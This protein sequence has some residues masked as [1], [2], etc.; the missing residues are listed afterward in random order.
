M[1]Y[2]QTPSNKKKG[3]GKT[4]KYGNQQENPKTVTLENESTPKQ[5]YKYPFLLCG[6]DHFTKECPRHEEINKFLKSNPTLVDLTDPFP[7][8]QQLI[9]H[10]FHGSSSSTEEIRMMSSKTVALTT[11]NQ[12]Y[13]KPPEMKDEGSSSK[14]T[15]SINPSPPP[16]SNGPLTIHKPSLDIIFHH[17]KSTI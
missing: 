4:K 11:R 7:S 3:K 9:D 15:P 10:T 14:K 6:G 13:D 2:S 12:T 16:H 1:Q 8:Q 17:P 5:K